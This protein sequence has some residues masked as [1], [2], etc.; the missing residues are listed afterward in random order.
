MKKS[1]ETF[2]TI[3]HSGRKLGINFSD[4]LHDKISNQNEMTPLALLI[5]NGTWHIYKNN[6]V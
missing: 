2:F 1:W 6:T 5:L 3:M 4:Y